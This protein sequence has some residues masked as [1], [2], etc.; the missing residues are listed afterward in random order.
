MSQHDDLNRIVAS[1]S[2][3]ALDDTRWPAASALIDDACR[4]K[5]NY[6]LYGHGHS[7]GAVQIFL[8]RLYYRGH[9][10]EEL[11]R[12]Y[13]DVYWQIDE[14]A[15]RIRRLPDSKLVHVRELYTTQELQ[16]SAVYNELVPRADTQNGLRVRLD[17]PI[18]HAYRLGSGRPHQRGRLVV[19]S[20]RIDR[21][22]L[23]PPSSIRELPPGTGR[24]RGSG[25]VAR[26]D[27]LTTADPASSSWIGAGKSWQQ[28]T[29][30]KTSCGEATGFPDQGG[31]FA[32]M[33]AVRRR[34][35][36]RAI[37][38][39]TTALRRPGRLRLN[40]REA[41]VGLAAAG[42]THQSGGGRST[43]LWPAACRRA[44]AD[45]RP[46][47]PGTDRSGA[48]VGVAWPHAGGGPGGGAVGRR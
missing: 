23:A 39:R 30:P 29:L 27:C 9:R 11:E 32:G 21:V 48:G 2:E 28:T 26:P 31:N 35:P 36:S 3:A 33:V 34:R 42:A 16:T 17:G 7:H 24:C 43:G 12:E 41:P 45:R 4:V 25:H 6:L 19:S 40:D 38:T 47:E 8:S 20:D 18:W 13:L 44:L 14:A 22:Y 15:P 5:G 37:G 1:L 10:H 46:G